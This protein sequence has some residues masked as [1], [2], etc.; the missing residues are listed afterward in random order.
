L[1]LERVSPALQN[2]DGSSGAIG[3]AVNHAIEAL[4]TIIASAPADAKTRESWLER[5]WEAHANDEIPYIERLGDFW[6]ELCV[7]PEIASAW[8]D[9]LAPIVELAWSSDRERRGC[10]HGT[11]ACFICRGASS[12]PP[13]PGSR[14]QTGPNPP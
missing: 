1:F 12:L 6:G 8:A 11:P 3:T 14:E 2:V 7:S 9:R 10:F 13:G 4:V 5:L